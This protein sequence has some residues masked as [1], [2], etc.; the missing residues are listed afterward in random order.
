MSSAQ[1]RPG[2]EPRRHAP[3]GSAVR[4]SR[5]PLNEGRG[6]NPGDTGLQP[7]PLRPQ[8]RSTKA[9]ARTPAT[10]TPS[11]QVIRCSSR[12]T[13]AGA[14]TPATLGRQRVVHCLLDALNEGRGANPG[15]TRGQRAVLRRRPIAQRRPGREPRRHF[16]LCAQGFS[17]SSPLNEGRGANPGDTRQVTTLEPKTYP[18]NEGRG[19]NPGDT[20]GCSTMGV[21]LS[22]AQRRPG[23]E[24]RRHDRS[25][26]SAGET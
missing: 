1:R 18:L 3:P 7:V 17:G 9:G 10:P 19:A 8:R 2:R 11:T 21:P 20:H 25:R 6:A 14:R 12:S 4:H 24:P 5:E 26:H 15:D 13:K 16:G 22:V 23:R